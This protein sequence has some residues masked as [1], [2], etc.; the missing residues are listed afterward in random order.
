[1]VTP[2]HFHHDTNHSELFCFTKAYHDAN[3]LDQQLIEL[4]DVAMCF[5][6]EEVQFCNRF[7]F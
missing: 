6:W 7:T 3:I 4:L 2:S 1:M 5:V